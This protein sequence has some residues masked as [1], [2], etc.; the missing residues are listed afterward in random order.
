MWGAFRLAPF[1]LWVAV[2]AALAQYPPA[3]N[4]ASGD[5]RAL[6]QA[7][8]ELRVDSARVYYVHELNLR[9]GPV[10]L[11]FV[12]GK[13][14]FLA[15]LEGRVT[16]AVFIGRG[17][18]IAMPRDPAERRS[19]A[20]FLGVPLLDQLFS[21]AYLRF[22]DDTS[23]AI[24]RQLQHAGTQ[25]TSD[26]ALADSWNSVIANLNPWH[27]RRI[28]YDW[29]SV[30]P[31]PFFYAG[32]GGDVTGVFDVL[33]DQRRDEQVFMGQPRT[34]RGD[35]FYDVWAS[36]ALDNETKQPS[37]VVSPLDYAIATTI[38][39][40]LSLQAKATV[41]LKELR[42]GERIITLELSRYLA[43]SG[44]A[45][46]SG[47]PLVFF[48]NDDVSRRDLARH[49]NDEL[50]VV[51]P[52]ATRAGE[53][54][55]LQITYHGNV[56][57][58]AGNGTYFVGERGSWYP[59]VGGGDHFV[60]FDLAFHWPKRLTLVATGN[61][62]E[63]REE[64][65][66]RYG[67]WRSSQPLALA[68]FNLGEYQTESASSDN[69]KIRLYANRQLEEAILA[70]L[71]DRPGDFSAE[72][73]PNI[74]QLRARGPTLQPAPPSPAAVL[75]HLGDEVLDSIRFF[76]KKNG[77]FPFDHLD[78]S[79]IPGTFGQGWPGLLYLPTIVFLPPEAQQEVG[80]GARTQQ[81]IN[82]MMPF[83]EVA[84]QWWGNEV[85]IASY[86]DNWIQEAMANY[87]A[88]WYA[89]NRKT[90][91]HLLTKWL[92]HYRDELL[93]KAG[94]SDET[95]EGAGSLSAG[96]RLDSSKTPDAYNTIIYGKGAWVVHMLRVMLRDPSSK[97]PDARFENFLRTVL[98]EHRFQALSTADLQAALE[99]FMT[100]AM[101]LEGGHSM[102]WFF[103][104]WVRGT[105]I[106]RY[107][108]EFQARPRGNEFVVTGKLKQ[109][110]V[111]SL[112][113]AAVPLHATRTGARPVWL[114]TVVTTGPVTRFHFVSRVYPGKI[115]I[116]PYLTLLC[117]SE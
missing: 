88:L 57:T 61:Q 33:V 106:P 60:P 9:R 42:P 10:S 24:E 116:D 45:D 23:G 107:S 102:D 25:A 21:R 6:Y 72:I 117:R 55:R 80:A 26:A 34:V 52:S 63:N 39:D 111:P 81:Q 99:K 70:R 54:L 22:N 30:N 27:S 32:L 7:L 59:H 112:F 83:H 8:N 94:S 79:Q 41:H 93:A 114:G 108:V 2:C 82:E 103:D 86:R 12:E 69:P 77:P 115:L 95:I 13:L 68:G 84:H 47:K 76:E 17:H 20:Q 75:K 113:T 90:S 14:A 104:E 110:Q 31:R 48:Q 73:S 28:L 56:I 50:L 65:G 40:D 100:P 74:D 43:V 46:E 35:R 85:G 109:A 87:L 5:A 97:T 1:V 78:V 19:L 53:E 36:F 101:D 3:A 67:H 18:V 105:G 66:Q 44:C 58:D 64:A 92:E 89:D 15:P 96:Y 16:G 49:G 62:L 11:T 4:P 38:A 37:E 98:T 51:L 91:A 71:R 29:L